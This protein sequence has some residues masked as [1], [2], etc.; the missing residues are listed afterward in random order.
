MGAGIVEARRRDPTSSYMV[1]YISHNIRIGT[2]YKLL[3]VFWA[4]HMRLLHPRIHQVLMTEDACIQL[5]TEPFTR[6]I[7]RVRALRGCQYY[8]D[9]PKGEYSKGECHG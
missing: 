8:D 1:M 9:Y 5:I 2:I 3:Y 4:T 6:H 7:T